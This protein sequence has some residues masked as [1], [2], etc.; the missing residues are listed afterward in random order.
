MRGSQ[1]ASP[2]SR[3]A[4]ACLIVAVVALAVYANTLGHGLVCDDLEVI[5]G[6]PA[7]ADPWDVRGLV[8]SPYRL[9][10]RTLIG[11]AYR[12]LT[13][14]SLALNHWV[15]EAMGR[16][17]EDPVGFHLLNIALHAGVSVL[18]L[19]WL[20]SLG[21]ERWPALGAALLFAVHPIHTEA[22]AAV[23]NRSEILAAL[24]GLSFL[25]LHRQRR[26][27]WLGALAYL[28]AM[29]G[30][31][32]A[33]AFLPLAIATD[34]LFPDR[35]PARRRPW[36][37]YVTSLVAM[38]AWLTL[39][40]LVMHDHPE[41]QATPFLDNPL[42]ALPPVTRILTAARL[43]LHYLRLQLDSTG[44]S[45]D[46]SFNQIPVVAGPADPFLWLAVAVL[47]GGAWAVWRLRAARPIVPLA[48]LGYPI[49]FAVTSNMV[50]TIGCT[51]E[52]HVY[53]PSLLFCVLLAEA[54]WWLA[55]RWRV[56]AAAGSAIVLVLF[57]GLTMA[58]N[59]TWAGEDAFFRAQATNAPDSV[60]AH[61]NLGSVLLKRGEAG[62]AVPEFERAIA[63]Y[64]NHPD[65]FYNLG[66][67]LRLSGAVPDRVIV[68][69]RGAVRLDPGNLPARSNLAMFL[70]HV[71][72]RR[73]ARQEVDEVA[74]LDPGYH[75]LPLLRQLLGRR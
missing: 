10:Q 15:N 27:A 31:E 71:G 35:D 14:W 61:Y 2:G 23:I 11:L 37:A 6:N 74:H 60:R 25:I 29:W 32:S 70:I 45:S 58:R 22:V 75:S 26:P 72:R 24:G 43:H 46:Y 52:R 44:L 62:A 65:L 38:G 3:P 59:R 28:G 53:A 41:A 54:G 47:A 67:A 8:T 42:I 5:P 21:M 20:V 9:G 13:V 12:P 34:W 4:L 56:A 73:E 17:G 50:V 33:I 55:G 69:Y 66:N 48:I 51:A 57:G 64:P 68:A 18:L 36:G 63:I 16:P 7:L 1:P 30:K 19:A 39:Y 40:R 49:L